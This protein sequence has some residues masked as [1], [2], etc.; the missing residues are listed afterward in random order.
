MEMETA[1]AFRRFGGGDSGVENNCCLTIC[2]QDTRGRR[3]QWRYSEPVVFAPDFR[4]RPRR[5]ARASATGPAGLE[6]TP[7]FPGWARPAESPS[8]AGKQGDELLELAHRTGGA[9]AFVGL[10]LEARSAHSGCWLDRLALWAAA[11]TV[12]LGGRAEGEAEIRDAWHLARPDQDAGPAGRIFALWRGIAGRSAPL[13]DPELPAAVIRG[14]GR[15][16]GEALT[17]T[18]AL[19]RT[20]AGGPLPPLA[21]ATGTVTGGLRLCPE[22]PV[23]SL[24]LADAVLACRLGWPVTVPLLAVGLDRRPLRP[25]APDWPAACLAAL[26]RG[27]AVAWDLHTGIGRRAGLLQAVRGRLRAKA[28]GIVVDALLASDALSPARLPGGMSDRAGRRLFDRLVAFGAVQELTGR[29]AFR[30]YGL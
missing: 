30:L 3:R 17:E 22:L 4:D 9:L 7:I 14:F 13:A 19:A 1:A 15:R 6:M 24:L 12:A 5:C 20:L 27:C 18:V 25:E 2:C 26:G 28:S 23:L 10:A 21:A 16:S 29:P 11:A 8:E